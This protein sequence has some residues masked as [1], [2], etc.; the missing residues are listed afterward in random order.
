MFKSKIFRYSAIAAAV[1][2]TTSGVLA[3]SSIL[4]T[5]AQNQAQNQAVSQ[6]QPKS[7]VEIQAQLPKPESRSESPSEKL[8]E[9]PNNVGMPS[10]KI[11]KQLNLSTEQLQKLKAARD[12]D[13]SSIRELVQQSRQ[14][15]KELRD[16]MAGTASS[17][18]IRTKHNQVLNLQ[19][20]LQKQHFERMLAMRD[21]LT[22]QQRSQLSEIMQKNRSDR[23]RDRM[24]NRL[25]KRMDKL[26]NFG[27]RTIQ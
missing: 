14:A 10:A 18:V 25:E 15:N 11:L 4:Q 22:P 17:D 9:R 24:Q 19:Q 23:P 12:R 6:A 5:Q 21:I 8:A 16:L 26:D 2:V 3:G 27:D 20:E 7:Q 1:A 13:S